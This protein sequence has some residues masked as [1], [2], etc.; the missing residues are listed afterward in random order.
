M[1]IPDRST[2]L[3]AAALALYLLPAG[4]A[5]AQRDRV[6]AA[7]GEASAGQTQACALQVSPAPLALGGGVVESFID[8][9]TAQA[10]I[11]RT[12]TQAGGKIDPDYVDNLRV[13]VRMDDGSRATVLI[14]KAMAVRI[15]DR[16]A[17]QSSY[18]SAKLPCNYVPNLVTIDLGPAPDQLA[19]SSPGSG[20]QACALRAAPAP[21]ALGGGVVESFI[22]R[23][24]AQALI[25]RTQA[26]AGGKID[27]DYVDNL[28]VAVRMDDGGR[29]TVLV[30]KAMVVQ[31]GDR[32]AVESSYRS[33]KLPCNYVPNLVT[34]DLGPSSAPSINGQP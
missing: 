11:G 19:A 28:R 10:M 9:A 3:A 23:E 20:A 16:V 27:P 22:D 18:R 2:A 14:P 32:V 17:V 6:S 12:Q 5:S 8:H 7:I 21:T 26:Q 13:A 15:G 31:V 25:G 4:P 34:A 33:A 24:T 29:A 30:P 1:N